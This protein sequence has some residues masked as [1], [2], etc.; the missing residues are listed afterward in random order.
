M[1]DRQLEVPV[2]LLL[3]R[4]SP[5]G[6]VVDDLVAAPGDPVHAV[7]HPRDLK[8]RHFRPAGK[9]V[10]W[11]EV[12]PPGHLGSDQRLVR[13]RGE[14]PLD[15]PEWLVEGVLMCAPNRDHTTELEALDA[16][17][18]VPALNKFLQE[19]VQALDRAARDLY[20]SYSTL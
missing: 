7:D 5:A 3:G 19:R 2:D 6:L 20:R 18:H 13:R 4:E 17:E 8:P 11:P 9:S 16:A 15:P 14:A 12:T 10:P 1:V